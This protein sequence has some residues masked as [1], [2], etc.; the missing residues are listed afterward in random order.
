[1]K[2][3]ITLSPTEEAN[4]RAWERWLR[5]HPEYI[6]VTSGDW[7][8]GQAT[9]Q[10]RIVLEEQTAARYEEIAAQLMPPL[11]VCPVGTEYITHSWGDSRRVELPTFS[12]TPTVV[13]LAVPADAPTSTMLG[14]I[15]VFEFRGPPGNKQLTVGMH[16]CD[17]RY[18]LDPAGAD[19]PMVNIDGKTATVGF[20]I[21]AGGSE[22]ARLIAGQTYYLS[23]RSYPD[24]TW[25]AAY[26]IQWPR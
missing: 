25:P 2:L 23:M 11:P 19:G 3:T 10:S 9:Y 6:G 7:N 1:M 22:D 13:T 16:A 4:L 26:E 17:W 5:T 24:G 20:G 14:T 21:N 18:V 8:D 12:L 15:R